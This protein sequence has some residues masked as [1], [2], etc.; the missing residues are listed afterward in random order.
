MKISSISYNYNYKLGINRYYNP[1]ISQF[2]ATDPLAEKYPG[3]LPYTYT[4]DNSV[5][6]VDTE[7]GMIER[8]KI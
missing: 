5:M 2:Y 4:A 3:M 8:C 7:R 1:R 6:L